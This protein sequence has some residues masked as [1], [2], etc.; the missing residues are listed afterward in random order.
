[1]ENLVNKSNFIANHKKELLYLSVG[2]IVTGIVLIILTSI[3]NV[4][5]LSQIC[6]TIGAVLMIIGTISIVVYFMK[7]SY[8]ESE[9][10][11][12][13]MGAILLLFGIYATLGSDEFARILS[14]LLSLC[15]AVDCIFKMQSSIRLLKSKNKISSVL[16]LIPLAIL[17]CA[18]IILIYPFEFNTLTR[19]IF[20]Y[21]T[22]I[23]DGIINIFYVIYLKAACL[24][25]GRSDF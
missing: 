20:T 23:L 7:K 3:T 11:G 22:I 10:S 1:M 2:Y 18:I 8:L 16:V 14:V 5:Y 24:F 19:D 21:I 15:V 25:P 17:I 9:K 12:F 13:L 6:F 4:I